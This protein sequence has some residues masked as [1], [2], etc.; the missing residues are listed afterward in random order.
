MILLTSGLQ[1]LSSIT[2]SSDFQLPVM[3]LGVLALDGAMGVSLWDFLWPVASRG[4]GGG[5]PAT[6]CSVAGMSYSAPSA[7]PASRTAESAHPLPSRN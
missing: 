4:G 1:W 5:E 7:V 3:E 6:L 2:S